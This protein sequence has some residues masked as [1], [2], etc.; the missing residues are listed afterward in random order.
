MEE[1]RVA[2]LGAAGRMGTEVCRTV[3]EARDMTLVASI[4]VDDPLSLLTDN[5]AQ[6]AV[7][8]THPDAVMGSLERCIGEGIHAVVGTTG[9]DDDR[10]DTVRRWVSNA[11]GIGVLIA[12]NFGIGA[13]LMMRFAAEAARFFESAEIVELHHPTKL[14]APSGTSIRTAQLIAGARAEAGLDAMPDAT[15]DNPLG[16]RGGTVD[17]VPVHSVRA[18]GLVAHQE[19]ILGNTGETLTIRHDMPDRIAAMPALVTAVKA[20]VE[21]RGLVVGLER[22]LG[23]DG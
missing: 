11:P 22:V 1:I 13:V 15:I 7:D 10:L 18:R 8:F 6:V 19:V 9:F 2:V 17:G 20:V 14:D 5:A 23:L 3:D 4:D 21:M 12:P 16:C